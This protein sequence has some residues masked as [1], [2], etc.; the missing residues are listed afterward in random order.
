MKSLNKSRNFFL[1]SVVVL[2]ISCKKDS[3]VLIKDSD[4]TDIVKS[5]RTSQKASNL[6]PVD[7]KLV[8]KYIDYQMQIEA[9]NLIK[10]SGEIVPINPIKIQR[11][12][13][14]KMID[15]FLA[16]ERNVMR[17][18]YFTKHSNNSF[19]L[20]SRAVDTTTLPNVTVV[21]TGSFANMNSWCTIL[22]Q[23]N[24]LY[25]TTLSAFS[26]SFGGGGGTMTPTNQL[27]QST[28]NGVITYKQY[29]QETFTLPSGVQGTQLYVMYGNVYHGACTVNGMKVIPIQ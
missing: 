7:L 3:S 22:F 11:A 28:S 20:L 6:E 9:N 4:K 5:A 19:G 23:S 25:G 27:I 14:N 16:N 2:I 17:Q 12:E 29:Y 21:C 1:F 8:E 10:N 18:D 26:F 15:N 24:V 13:F